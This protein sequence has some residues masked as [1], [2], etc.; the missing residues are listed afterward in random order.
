[1]GQKVGKADFQEDA[2]PFV[3][4]PGDAIRAIWQE[5]NLYA[6]SWGIDAD[7]CKQLCGAVTKCL[8]M[9]RNDKAAEALFQA[10][11]TDKNGLVDGL[12]FISSIGL[13]SGMTAMEK[14]TFLFTCFDI[15]ERSFLSMEELF[16]LLKSCFTGLCKLS[17]VDPPDPEQFEA[18]AQLVLKQGEEEN[19]KPN[20]VSLDN[21][22]EYCQNNPVA[23]S[24]LA[25]Y[26]D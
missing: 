7:F 9:E 6:D 11:D 5:F 8:G 21:F 1:M 17:S 14:V 13:V 24:W 18:V 4:L 26:D 25:F 2:K 12:E 19:S 20:G 3:N 22:S 10:L 15:G 16:L 23:C